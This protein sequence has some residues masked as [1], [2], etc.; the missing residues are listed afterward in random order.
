MLKDEKILKNGGVGIIPTDTI[1]GIACS[2]FSKEALDR[3]FELKGRDENKPPVV[4]V[5]DISDLDI[6]GIKVSEKAKNFIEKYWPGKVSIIFEV[7]DKFSYLDKG[8]GLAIRLPKDEK[9]R[10][11]LRKTGPIA[12]SSANIQG[13]QP[14]KNIKEAKKYFGDKVD[15]YIDEGEL[16]SEPSTLVKIVGDNIEILRQGAVRIVES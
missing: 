3:L 15:F 5:A 2:V 13:Q 1:Y 11:F 8:R 6:F 4:I 16:I 12:T 7:L 9:I 10:E 14:A